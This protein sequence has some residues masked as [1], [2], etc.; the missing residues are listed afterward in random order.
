[1]PLDPNLQL[2]IEDE[3][4]GRLDF[5]YETGLTV[6]ECQG[7]IGKSVSGKL[8]EYETMIEDGILYVSFIDQAKDTGGLFVPPPQK[9]AVRFESLADKTVIRVRYVWGDDLS[10]PYIL[11]EDINTFFSALFYAT[12][13]ESDN[14]IWTDSAEE[15]VKNDSLKLYGS[16][17]FWIVSGI[18]VILWIL[19]AL[20]MY[21]GK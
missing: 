21:A 20:L 17:V 4:A 8:S 10:V 7:R 3:Q 18:F 9:Y 14:K 1:M 11:R 2:K 13:S 16:K 6:S 5:V 19:T 15:I 12:V